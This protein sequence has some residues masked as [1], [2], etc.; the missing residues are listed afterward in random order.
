MQSYHRLRPSLGM[1][2]RLYCFSANA[3]VL[4]T[5][6]RMCDQRYEHEQLTHERKMKVLITGGAGFPEM[7]L[8]RHLSL[9][10]N[11]VLAPDLQVDIDSIVLSDTLVPQIRPLDLDQLI[12]FVA[13]D[14]SDCAAVTQLVDCDD[15]IFFI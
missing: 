1:L 14:I 4:L 2:T 13:V 7:N 3:F 15:M 11:L 6:F 10:P 9:K 8:A 12:T 5:A